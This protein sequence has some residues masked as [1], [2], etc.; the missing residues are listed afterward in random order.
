MNVRDITFELEERVRQ[1]QQAAD[2]ATA[3]NLKHGDG[4]GTSGGMDGRVSRLEAHMEHVREDMSEIKV[5]I[6]EMSAKIDGFADRLNGVGDR[7]NGLATKSD[8]WAWKWQW[9]AICVAAVALI[10]GGII[11]GLAW[12]KPDVSPPQVQPIVITAPPTPGS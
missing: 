1:Q 10:V 2:E 5:A 3:R 9:T 7:L 8:L 4:D 12:I 11:G 6:K